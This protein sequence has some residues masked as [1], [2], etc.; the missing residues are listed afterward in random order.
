MKDKKLTLMLSVNSLEMGGAEQQLLALVKG[1]D[2]KRFKPIV[3][4]L[5]PGGDLEQEIKA[6]PDT[7][8]ICLNR[9]DKY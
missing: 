4:T 2:R 7:E 5:F 1:L 3:V 9:K 8:Y 6:I